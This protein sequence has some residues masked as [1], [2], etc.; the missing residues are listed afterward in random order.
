MFWQGAA[1]GPY[2]TFPMP[3]SASPC[4]CLLS[5]GPASRFPGV[6]FHSRHTN[7]LSVILNTSLYFHAISLKVLYSFQFRH[8]IIS[9]LR[10][11][12]QPRNFVLPYNTFCWSFLCLAAVLDSLQQPWPLAFHI[13]S[14]LIQ[15]NSS[16]FSVFCTEIRIL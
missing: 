6:C 5:C 11:P 8:I 14:L 4:C 13:S 1:G 12:D 7:I 15:I 16:H 10:T 9:T 3:T 2:R